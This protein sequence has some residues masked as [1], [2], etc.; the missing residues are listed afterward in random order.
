MIL[1]IEAYTSRKLT[2]DSDSLNAFAGILR[3]FQIRDENHDNIWGIPYHRRPDT[4]TKGRYTQD[5]TESSTEGTGTESFGRREAVDSS[6]GDAVAGPDVFTR[7]V[8]VHSSPREINSSEETGLLV[9]LCWAHRHP[10]WTGTTHLR[11]P[12]RRDQFPSWSWVGW[13]GDAYWPASSGSFDKYPHLEQDEL[14]EFSL[15]YRRRPSD[16]STNF[17]GPRSAAAAAAA[18]ALDESRQYP[19]ALSLVGRVVPAINAGFSHD[20][21]GRL[22]WSIGNL[23]ASLLPSAGPETPE[24]FLEALRRGSISIVWLATTSYHVRPGRA[25][26]LVVQEARDG[27]TR[28]IGMAIIHCA[29][30]PLESLAELGPS[31]QRCLEQRAFV[32]Y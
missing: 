2:F 13:E 3:S 17:D 23:E 24:A 22:R 29:G 32:L 21:R 19:E 6:N 31:G 5:F 12:R 16:P 28:R 10:H 30:Q 25:W 11:R 26:C 1:A 18:A 15:V 4:G 7:T 27:K 20:D 9:R 8:T 14:L